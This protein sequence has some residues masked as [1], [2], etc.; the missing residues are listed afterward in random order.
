[1]SILS[2]G[3]SNFIPLGKIEMILDVDTKPIKN[4][5]S[6]KHRE[7]KKIDVTQGK[8]TRSLILTTNG[9]AILSSNTPATLAKR[10]Q[11]AYKKKYVEFEHGVYSD[12]GALQASIAKEEI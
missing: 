4:L 8:K 2:V 6:I 10:Y 1:M 12:M 7:Q 9:Y 5:I 3:N 11:D